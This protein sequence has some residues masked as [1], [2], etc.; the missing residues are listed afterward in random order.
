MQQYTEPATA[1]V[2]DDDNLTAAPWGNAEAHGSDVAYRR[3][4]GDDWQDV[5]FAAFRDEVAAVAKG[6]LA[7]GLQPGDRVGLISQTRYEWTLI[8]YALWAAGAVTLPIYETSS[9]DQ[10][11]WCLSDSGARGVVVESD[12]HRSIV[13]DLR[14]KLPDLGHVWQIDGSG[15]TGGAGGAVDA[16]REAGAGVDDATLEQRRTS[17]HADDL[18]TLIYTSGTTG[19]PKGC[20]ITH[21]NLLFE[22]RAVADTFSDLMQPGNS[23]LLFLPLAH[24]FARVIQ[25]AAMEYRYVIG[26]FADTKK[27]TTE[28]PRFRPD[29]LLSVPRVF[30]KVYN[31][32]KAKAHNEGKGRIFDMAEATAVSYSESLDTGGPGIALRFQ[33]ALFDKLVYGKLRAALGGRCVGAVSGGSALGAR[34]GHFFRGVGVPIHEGYGLTE[35]SAA[36]TA[37]P[38]R[39]VRIGT[40][41]KPIPGVTIAIAEDGEVL[42]KGDVVFRGY[43]N[44]PEA[45]KSTIVDGWFHTG[46]LG[47]LDDDGYLS[48]TGRK[49]ELIVT[50]G[51]KNVAPAVLEDRVR[52]HR[53][54]S[55]ALVVGDNRP[56]IGALITLDPEALPGWSSEHGKDASD[57]ASLAEDPDVQA[58]I[59]GAIEEANKAVSRAEAIRQWRILASDFTEESGELTPT[60][61]L[62][63][64]VIAEKRAD[65]IEAV[66]QG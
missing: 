61:K 65:D 41:G 57:A 43:W 20:E 1:K 13:E 27:L 52:A 4:V 29:F 48:I 55:Q 39:A 35:T 63:R 47:S 59:S 66:Y 46:D 38:N 53:L 19:R 14:E 45:T 30:E 2:A 28:L 60:M 25:C 5:T 10:V 32:A 62:K 37:N 3:L 34:I 64:N 12:E 26:H 18:A 16:L 31:G 56:Y 24:I 8:D 11:E 42:A 44:N 23:T 58:E 51:G 40:V 54:V 9:A 17:V 36:I 7:A 15:G 33:H 50:A 22:V 21:R 49:K 6:F